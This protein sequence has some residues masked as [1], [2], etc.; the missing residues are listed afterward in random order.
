MTHR[1]NLLSFME[2]QDII[3]W[4]ISF[5]ELSRICH[6]SEEQRIEILSQIID[7]NIQ[8]RIYASANSDEVINK[9][10]K[11]KYN[12][13]SA[14]KYQTKLYSLR[15]ED[16]ITIRAYLY[17]IERNVKK[18]AICLNWSENIKVEKTQEIFYCGL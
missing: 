9:L 13:M 16:F 14:Y 15:Q 1:I 7:V 18:L 2:N 17:H 11:P 6:W 8:H 5:N 3:N 4:G 10:L 12:Y